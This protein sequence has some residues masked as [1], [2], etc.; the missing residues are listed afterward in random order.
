MAAGQTRASVAIGDLK[1]GYIVA[2][3]SEPVLKQLREVAAEREVPIDDL[4][5]LP[6][7]CNNQLE[8]SPNSGRKI[9]VRETEKVVN[10]RDRPTSRDWTARSAR[11]RIAG[12]AK[13]FIERDVPGIHR[14]HSG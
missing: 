5:G 7:A 2:P 9:R 8:T 13:E 1:N 4:G 14:R 6:L 10:G 12:I 11:R 3:V